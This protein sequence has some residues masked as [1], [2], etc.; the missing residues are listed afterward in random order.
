MNNFKSYVL[1]SVGIFSLAASL[2]LNIARANHAEASAVTSATAHFSSGRTYLLSPAN[3]SSM[4]K[5]KVNS[6]DGDWLSCE[7]SSWVNINA[8]ISAVDTR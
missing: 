5:C 3:G 6:V 4:I 7:D 1:A 8:M 2:T